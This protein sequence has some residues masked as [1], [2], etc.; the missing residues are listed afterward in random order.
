M[1]RADWCSSPGTSLR[2]V[3]IAEEV[4]FVSSMQGWEARHSLWRFMFRWVA[5]ATSSQLGASDG[6]SHAAAER[7]GILDSSDGH[8]SWVHLEVLPGTLL[9][10][11][12]GGKL[13][14]DQFVI[15]ELL[16]QKGIAGS[17]ESVLSK[18]LLLFICFSV[19]CFVHSLWVLKITGAAVKCLES[20]R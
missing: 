16:R 18:G 5:V 3:P 2:L 19:K 10:R 9:S 14:V 4:N 20:W 17:Q 13:R 6:L 1:P 11:K 7:P 8:Y 12:F 15:R